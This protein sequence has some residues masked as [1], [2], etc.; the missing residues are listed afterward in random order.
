MMDERTSRI[1]IGLCLLVLV[2]IGVYW[3]WQPEQD[4]KQPTITFEQQPQSQPPITNDPQDVS[5]PSDDP[6]PAIIDQ[7]RI[8]QQASAEP[9]PPSG[10]TLRA[11]EFFEH[12]VA[13]NE[14]MEII[15]QKY[16]GASN[17]W[18]IIARANPFVDPQKLK[19]GM[20]IRVPKDPTNIQGRVEGRE[21]EPG[22][23]ENHTP[24]RAAVI[25]YVVRPGDS[26][27]KI[28]LNIYGSSRH[29]RLIFESNRDVL[30]S[31]DDI[32][33]GQLL[34]LPPLPEQEPETP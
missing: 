8:A 16:F 11:P 6:G 28:S 12:T 32:S 30:K 5:P 13:S 34:K 7:T 19:E 23:I 29:A 4:N 21:T 3:M 20:K 14:T 27:S 2:W 9:D 31:M 1:F 26:L 17:Q 18:G 15:A 10:P 33:V 22:V 25:E 24:E